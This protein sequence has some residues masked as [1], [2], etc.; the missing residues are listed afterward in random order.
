MLFCVYMCI[1]ININTHN[2]YIYIHTYKSHNLCA[3]VIKMLSGI[4]WRKKNHSLY[5]VCDHKINEK[6]IN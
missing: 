5:V 6:L 3:S 2:I 4:V 1:Y